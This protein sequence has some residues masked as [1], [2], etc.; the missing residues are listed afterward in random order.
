MPSTKDTTIIWSTAWPMSLVLLDTWP[1]LG[2]VDYLDHQAA[3]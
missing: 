2:V 3:R 1:L